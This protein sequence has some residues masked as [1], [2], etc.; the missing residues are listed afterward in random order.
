[1]CASAREGLRAKVGCAHR[2]WPSHTV[3][4]GVAPPHGQCQAEGQD[5]RDEAEKRRLEDADRLAQDLGVGAQVPPQDDARE[6]RPEHDREDEQA[7][8]EDTRSAGQSI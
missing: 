5:E 4:G 3:R 6:R 7:E 2:G 1:M 8:L